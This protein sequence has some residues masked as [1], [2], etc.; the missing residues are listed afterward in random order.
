[1]GAIAHINLDEIQDAAH[2]ARVI[3]AV[4]MDVSDDEHI[5]PDDMQRLR[6]FLSGETSFLVAAMGGSCLYRVAVSDAVAELESESESEP[7]NAVAAR[8]GVGANGHP[9]RVS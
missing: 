5:Q 4:L 6:S 9:S 8:L 3:R 2:L 1:M 7:E